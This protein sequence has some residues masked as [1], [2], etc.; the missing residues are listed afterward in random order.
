MWG[1]V[2]P[3]GRGEPSEGPAKAKAGPGA[4]FCWRS[5]QL[6][7]FSSLSLLYFYYCVVW[8]VLDLDK[9]RT[10]TRVHH[11]LELESKLRERESVWRL[12][13][14]PEKAAGFWWP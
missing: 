1:R 10:R 6:S 4:C 5:S 12:Q 9:C 8:H 11:P 7:S 3:V 14:V 2:R 13:E